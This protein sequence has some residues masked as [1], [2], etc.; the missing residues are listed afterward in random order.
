MGSLN[1]D[2]RFAIRL[3]ARTP[4]ITILA[5]LALAL[6]IGANTAI[7]SLVNAALL[8]PLP[9]VEA[10]DRLIQLER[11]PRDNVSYN[12]GYPDYTDYRDRNQTSTELAAHV[13][14]PLSFSG[15]TATQ[16][17]GE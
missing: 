13:G 15:E 3:L 12:F 5:M 2:I 6:G 4:G 1:R 9:G 8:Q 7:F 10:P 11:L 16:V 17:R 14:T